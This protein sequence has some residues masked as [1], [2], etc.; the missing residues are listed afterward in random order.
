MQTNTMVQ[1]KLVRGG[2]VL[3]RHKAS[4]MRSQWTSFEKMLEVDN[5]KAS[6]DRNT[7]GMI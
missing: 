3:L 5:E 2:T 4:Q 1:K 7:S 6:E